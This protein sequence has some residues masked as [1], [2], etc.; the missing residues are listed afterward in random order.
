MSSPS[1]NSNCTPNRSDA[2]DSRARP[3][4]PPGDERQE[5]HPLTGGPSDD[6]SSQADLLTELEA[7]AVSEANVAQLWILGSA[8]HPDLLDRWSDIDVGLVLTGPV[9]LSSLLPSGSTVWALDRQSS[10]AR[11]TCRVVLDDGRRVDL[12]VA[13]SSEFDLA[14][15]RCAYSA[16][17]TPKTAIGGLGTHDPADATVNTVR[18][19]AA[20]AVVK[21]GRGDLLIGS[22]LTLE[23]AQLCL[24]EAMLLRDRDEGTTSHRFGTGRDELAADT[25]SALQLSNKSGDM[26]ILRLVGQFDR[27]HSELDQSYAPDWSGLTSLRRA[28]S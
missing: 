6:G 10:D 17:R 24:V 22:H 25:W 19:I 23:L 2:G 18:F 26:R 13:S 15:G 8:R 14:G 7:A 1:R 28:E 11:S 20:Q 16:G 4:D 5:G 9:A 12:V 21:Y 3:A 27:L